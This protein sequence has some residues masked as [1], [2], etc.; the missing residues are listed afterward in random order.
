MSFSADKILCPVDFS[1][2]SREAMEI[3]ADMARK[4]ESSLTLLHV[5]QLPSIALPDGAY[6][7]PSTDVGPEIDETLA[8]WR[9]D[10]IVRGVHVVHTQ[11]AIGI[12]HD[13]IL[14]FAEEGGYGLIVLGTHG[15]TGLDHLL[16]GSVA[17]KVVRR[18][19]CPVLTVR[20]RAAR[21]K[22]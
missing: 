20:P 15:R 6:Y 8:E 19:P 18:A 21:E 1:E 3:A 5:I 14:K 9:K 4:L 2:A 16:I 13:E 11:R 22:K 10:V 12:P 17:E 7:I